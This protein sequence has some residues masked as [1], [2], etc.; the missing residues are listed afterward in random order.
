MYGQWPKYSVAM[1]TQ[2]DL[3]GCRGFVCIWRHATGPPQAYI[4]IFIYLFT[5]LFMVLH[6]HY[7]YIHTPSFSYVS[8][9]YTP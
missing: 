2:R 9:H 4:Y 8:I 1:F 7:I 3:F 6:M 5:Y